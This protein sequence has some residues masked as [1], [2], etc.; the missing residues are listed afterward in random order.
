MRNENN[1]NGDKQYSNEMFKMLIKQDF[2][3]ESRDK[4]IKKK[5]IQKD[6]K[7]LMWNRRV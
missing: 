6:I 2:K 3:G 5:K 4:A 1:K 7:V